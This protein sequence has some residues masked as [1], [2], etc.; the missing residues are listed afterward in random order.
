MLGEYYVT[1]SNM[2]RYNEQYTSIAKIYEDLED[3]D[4]ALT[5]LDKCVNDKYN[6]RIIEKKGYILIKSKKY[7]EASDVF[8]KLMEDV[9]EKRMMLYMLNK[10]IFMYMLCFLASDDIVGAILN[11]ES[12]SKFDCTF[13][14]SGKGIFIHN[15]IKALEE[16]NITAFELACSQ[17]SNVNKLEPDHV[18]LL[19]QIKSTII[20]MTDLYISDDDSDIC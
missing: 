5:M 12:I 4:T 8:K 15:I 16:N 19:T 10:H 11:F 7:K 6:A 2:S 20:T 17:F 14:S 1:D 3:Y 9:Y 18:T 13:H